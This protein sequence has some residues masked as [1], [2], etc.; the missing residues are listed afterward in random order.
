MTITYEKNLVGWYVIKVNGL[1]ASTQ[2]TLQAC[3]AEVRELW[4]ALAKMNK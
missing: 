1:R 2:P 4:L 3:K